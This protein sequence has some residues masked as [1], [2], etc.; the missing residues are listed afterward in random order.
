MR[1]PENIPCPLHMGKL[2]TGK[3]FYNSALLAN[4][5]FG[6]PGVVSFAL[7]AL[8]MSRPPKDSLMRVKPPGGCLKS[9]GGAKYS[10][11]V[12]GLGGGGLPLFLSNYLKLNTEVVEL[13]KEVVKLAKRHFEC[14]ASP[15][16]QVRLCSSRFWI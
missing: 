9:R 7:K 5:P 3:L 13:D 6:V 10:A 12:I 4:V 11:V 15:F 8:S 14:H 16:L 1:C 2:H